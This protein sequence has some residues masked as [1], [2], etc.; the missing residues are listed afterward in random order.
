MVAAKG[1][2]A[3]LMHEEPLSA[4]QLKEKW[5]I[6]PKTLGRYF[7]DGLEGYKIGGKRFTT[8]EALGRFGELL[9]EPSL[10]WPTADKPRR[11]A[12]QDQDEAAEL[13]GG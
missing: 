7:A 2:P 4:K 1:I 12:K 5:G 11:L 9:W 3:W 6:G 8:V 10:D 13:L